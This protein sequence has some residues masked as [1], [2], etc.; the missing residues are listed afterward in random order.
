MMLVGIIIIATFGYTFNI[1][2]AVAG[3]SNNL[4]INYSNLKTFTSYSNLTEFLGINSGSSYPLHGWGSVT[5]P[6]MLSGVAPR[7]FTSAISRFDSALVD[8]SN[9]AFYKED[10]GYLIDYSQTNVQVTGVDEPDFVKTD[11]KYLYIVHENKVLIVK[12]TPAKDAKIECE[13]TVNDVSSILNIFIS[14][15][16]LVIFTE[17]YNYPIYN[18]PE[19]EWDWLDEEAIPR[20]ISIDIVSPPRWYSS[21]DTHVLVYD[22]ANLEEPDLVKDV[23]VP[24]RFSSARLI[25][26]YVYVITTQYPYDIMYLESNQTAIPRIM[27]NN[28]VKEIPVS[29]IFYVDTC[30][31]SKT[32][33]NIVSVNIK[34][35]EENVT[36]KMFFL[37]NTQL[38]YVSRTNI[39][40]VASSVDYYSYD[41]L[42]T[43]VEEII[44]PRLNDSFKQD[45]QL[46]ENFSNLDE[47]QKKSVTEWILQKYVST[48][49]EE[50]KLELYNE[51]V[52]RFERTTIHRISIDA[53][54]I[55]YAAQADIPGRIQN[56]F[57]L[58][59]HDGYLRVSSTV[60]G[61]A[62]SNF[63][64]IWPGGRNSI[65]VLDM[66]LEIVGSLEDIAPGEDIYATR[67]LGEKC[68]LVT[69]RQIDPFFVIDLSDPT[70]PTK[71]GELKIPGYS[72]YLHP[73]DE[74]HVIGIGMEN[75]SIKI[76]LFDVSDMSNPV[77]LSKYIIN[78]DG[79]TWGSGNSYAL[80]EHKA[81]LFDKE[82]NLLVIPAGSYYKQSAYVFNITI[83]NG[84]KLLGSVTHENNADENTKEDY[85]WYG[86]D[87]SYSIKRSLYIGD[88]LY[89]ISDN[90]VKMNS[91]DDLSEINSIKLK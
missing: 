57:Q 14:N 89:T 1:K 22:L 53:S 71:L 2:T 13:I 10:G 48:L 80:N 61:N 74:T 60:E 55:E 40:L 59:E 26:D 5:Q 90:M 91:L 11:G 58:N 79:D 17:T 28:V 65:Y 30:D 77:E 37:G 50:E 52:K 63:L 38:L 29:N 19:V 44:M 73:Y 41:L 45:I 34:D 88:V 6:I 64:Y 70:N 36:A 15:N 21:P 78:N 12:A 69:F 42:K 84:L 51:T 67:F 27:V 32:I 25:F 3:E 76:S 24:G 86:Y 16:T 66:D 4:I 83:E 31:E 39:Y 81:F 68:Y 23:V 9:E 46:V 87:N 72:T 54:K 75:W 82:K 85:Y 8:Y 49:T 33:T 62:V 35:D 43:I 20:D 7:M 18:D 56:Q 47:Y